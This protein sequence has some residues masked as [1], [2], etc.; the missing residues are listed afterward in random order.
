MKKRS[1]D[2]K[3][4]LKNRFKQ[5]AVVF[6]I[7]YVAQ[8]VIKGTSDTKIIIIHAQAQNE[9][10]TYEEIQ[11]ISDPCDLKVVE[12]PKEYVNT[13]KAIATTYNPEIGQ[14]DSTP[15]IMANGKRVHEKAVASNCHP[16]G[17]K[18]EVRGMGDYTVEDRMNS[19][20]TKDCGTDNERIDFF[21]WNRKDNFKK[22]II[23]SVK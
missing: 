2:V 12:C 18:I 14:T 5:A 10:Y 4:T 8:G 3:S 1:I 17:T 7:V 13:H 19:R 16:F 22:D 6:L 11:P 20:Y 9:A 15:E 21:K 23:Y